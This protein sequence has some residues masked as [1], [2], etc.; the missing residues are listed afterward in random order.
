MTEWK[1]GL[2][3]FGRDPGVSAG[4]VVQQHAL[5]Y[6]TGAGRVRGVHFCSSDESVGGASDGGG[7]LL[8]N[9]QTRDVRLRTDSGAT[10]QRGA[11]TFGLYEIILLVSE[12][13]S[14]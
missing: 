9:H 5:L 7:Y 14:H 13:L 1:K 6:G 10:A 11:V 12:S 3:R 2:T 4:Y 8:C